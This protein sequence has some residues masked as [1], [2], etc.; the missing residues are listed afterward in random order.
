MDAN[1]YS[2][3]VRTLTR[4]RL[5]WRPVRH[6]VGFDVV[7][8]DQRRQRHDVDGV[9]CS[10]FGPDDGEVAQASREC[11]GHQRLVR[12]PEPSEGVH[13][14][15]PFDSEGAQCV[16]NRALGAVPTWAAFADVTPP[17]EL[18]GQ[19]L[20]VSEMGDSAGA[21]GR[22]RC[23]NAAATRDMRPCG[24]APATSFSP[25]GRGGT[26]PNLS[27]GGNEGSGRLRFLAT[28]D[29]R[30]GQTMSNT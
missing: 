4:H 15:C 7:Q 25:R 21:T 23:P 24:S 28:R 17:T 8:E 27:G 9:A 30:D 1:C 2:I 29:I 3:R 12:S 20:P 18:L 10:R 5:D 13:P 26:S 19:R 22:C 14:G 16:G 6:V 11:G